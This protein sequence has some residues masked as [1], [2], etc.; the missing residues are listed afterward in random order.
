[1]WK[2]LRLSELDWRLEKTGVDGDLK[3]AID[4]SMPRVRRGCRRRETEAERSHDRREP[5]ARGF[6]GGRFGA[7]E[8]P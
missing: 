7:G 6:R 8:F 2:G 1:M 4:D 3:A 5:E